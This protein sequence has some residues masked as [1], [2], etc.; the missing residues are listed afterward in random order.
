MKK[1][2]TVAT[3]TAENNRLRVEHERDS[4]QTRV[5][6]LRRIMMQQDKVIDLLRQE[7]V[8]QLQ[9][10]AAKLRFQTAKMI[11]GEII[12]EDVRQL[13]EQKFSELMTTWNYRWHYQRQCGIE[14]LDSII[15]DPSLD[16][17]YIGAYDISSYLGIPGDT[18]NPKVKE[19]ITECT[20]RIR[21]KGKAVGALF[22]DPNELRSFNDLGIQLLC[23]RV[24][25]DLLYAALKDIVSDFSKG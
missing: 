25:S 15:D 19:I 4:L 14:N 21:S 8:L 5:G 10:E 22:H 16:M 6:K 24:D 20:K 1:I 18:S 11:A 13:N 12:K 7:K 2:S 17:V 9:A 23:Y 3:A